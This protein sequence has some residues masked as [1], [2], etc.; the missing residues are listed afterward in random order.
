METDMNANVTSFASRPVGVAYA[1]KIAFCMVAAGV[2][3]CAGKAL[4]NSGLATSAMAQTVA[5]QPLATI[6]EEP[7]AAPC[8][9]VSIEIDE[10][11]GVRGHVVRQL[12]GK[13]L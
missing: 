12:C 4:L 2:S 1:V 11:Y 13:A 8:R 5:T 7:A 3:L 10:G 6:I 9:D